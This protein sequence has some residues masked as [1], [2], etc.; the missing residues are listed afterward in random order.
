MTR[1]GSD[2]GSTD[3]LQYIHGDHCPKEDTHQRVEVVPYGAGFAVVLVAH[4]KDCGAVEHEIVDTRYPPLDD[5]EARAIGGG[6]R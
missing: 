2:I 1:K 5:E 4:C 6:W 3:P